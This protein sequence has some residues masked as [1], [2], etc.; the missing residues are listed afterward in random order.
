MKVVQVLIS[1]TLIMCCNVIKSSDIEMLGDMGDALIGKDHSDERSAYIQEFD[2]KY[3]KSLSSEQ[4]HRDSAQKS[5]HDIQRAGLRRDTGTLHL[6]TK[7]V[8]QNNL[9]S[10]NANLLKKLDEGIEGVG[11]DSSD[12]WFD[13]KG[14]QKKEDMMK[15]LNRKIVDIREQYPNDDKQRAQELINVI[16]NDT[17]LREFLQRPEV[18]EYYEKQLNEFCT[19][20][21]L[22]KEDVIKKL[23]EWKLWKQVARRSA[24]GFLGVI[25]I[26]VTAVLVVGELLSGQT[27]SSTRLNSYA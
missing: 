7:P 27:T 4:I 23:K 16:D 13:G 19:S 11:I 22:E 10:E 5:A 24:K 3:R 2:K 1:L 15:F 14:K 17:D 20:N 26:A 6:G 12:K 18:R 21:C 8:E 9:S 25:L